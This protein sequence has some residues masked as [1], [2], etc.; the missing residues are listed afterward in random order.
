ML[1]NKI[2]NFSIQQEH[3]HPT[4]QRRT[5][6]GYCIDEYVKAPQAEDGINKLISNINAFLAKPK[7]LL[8]EGFRGI[9][10]KI[11]DRYA[12]KRSKH[13]NQELESVKQNS[14]IDFSSLQSYYGGA[15]VTFNNGIQILRNV[16]SNGKQF[17]AGIPEKESTMMTHG[18]KQEYW[19]NT[20]LPKFAELPQKSFDALAKDFSALNKISEQGNKYTFDTINPN[21]VILIGK[22]T[23]RIV[24]ELDYSYS[25]NKNTTAGLL[26]LLLEK[27]DLDY[28]A[29]KDITNQAN[30][31]A[32]F[33][34]IILAGEKYNLTL[35][36]S[37]L[38]T[39]TW[40]NVTEEFCEPREIIEGLKKLRREIPDTKTRLEETSKFIDEILE[41]STG[42]YN[43][44]WV[45]Y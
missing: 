45:S 20:Y 7:K 22:N 14:P 39:N 34:K 25:L 8:G 33:K 21:N 27:M 24:D 13:I 16:S 15:V 10:Y 26:R 23:L 28:L 4:F 17:C 12:L 32:L 43:S 18:E 5:K 38:D 30:R 31:K 11:D 41:Q 37:S 29:P 35:A 19:S 44:L 1:I 40:R 36:N 2:N 42:Y 9:V 6:L 3:Q